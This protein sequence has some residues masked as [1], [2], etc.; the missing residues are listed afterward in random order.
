MTNKA[1][2]FSYKNAIFSYLWYGRIPLTEISFGALKLVYLK[3]LVIFWAK[4]AL[5]NPI[6]LQNP[7]FSHMPGSHMP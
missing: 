3:F 2:K 6:P 7:F 5:D 4:K 1:K